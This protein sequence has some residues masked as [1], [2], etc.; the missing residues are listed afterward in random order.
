M[1]INIVESLRK[2]YNDVH[3]LM[4]HRS[5]ERA[6][7]ETELFDILDTIPS[8]YPLIWSEKDHRW[9]STKDVLQVNKFKLRLRNLK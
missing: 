2:R 6:K 1:K 4:F 7:D 9:K 8:K 3:P 5:L